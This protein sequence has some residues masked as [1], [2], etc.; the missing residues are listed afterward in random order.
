[1]DGPDGV[2]T[3]LDGIVGDD[4]IGVGGLMSEP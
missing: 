3:G 4:A 2:V 1:V